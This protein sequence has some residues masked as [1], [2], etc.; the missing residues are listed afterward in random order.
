MLL[1]EHNLCLV[2]HTARRFAAHGAPV[3]ELISEGTIGLIKAVR[4]YDPAR[5]IKL[6]TYATRCIENEM[7]MY[8]RRAQARH[9]ELS[10][11]QPLYYDGGCGCTQ[12]EAARLTGVTQGYISRVER[13]TLARLRAEILRIMEA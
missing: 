13:R 4:S 8:F 3:E 5:C 11:D 1:V 12:K 6:S 7:R 2:V 10:L 9:A